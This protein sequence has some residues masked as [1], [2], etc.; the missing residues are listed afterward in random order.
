MKINLFFILIFFFCHL[1][2]QETNEY[3]DLFWEAQKKTSYDIDGAINDYNKLIKLKPLFWAAYEYRGKC[4]QTKSDL[5]GAIND[6]S[7]CINGKEYEIFY[8]SSLLS[9]NVNLKYEIETKNRM[10]GSVYYIRGFCKYKLYDFRSAIDDFTKAILLSGT[11]PS[12]NGIVHEAYC[13]RGVCKVELG[14]NK[15]ALN[16][17]N[18]SIKASPLYCKAF[19]FR[20]ILKNKLKLNVEACKDLSRSGELG[21]SEAYEVIKDICN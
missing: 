10:L 19:F 5:A 16:D 7:Q 3:L 8:D 18:S 21:C 12:S 17:Y 4:K 9:S 14:D 15:G 13:C 1:S 11:D 2:G 6:Y 20:G